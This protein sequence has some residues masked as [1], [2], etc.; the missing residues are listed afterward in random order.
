V[1]FGFLLELLIAGFFKF[2][3]VGLN[4]LKEH[5]MVLSTL[6]N[7]ISVEGKNQLMFMEELQ[8]PLLYLV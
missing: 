1:A 3:Q 5:Y 6:G 8:H 2:G 4:S 7:T